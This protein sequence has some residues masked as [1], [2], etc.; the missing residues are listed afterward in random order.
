[1][2]QA[3]AAFKKFAPKKILV[4]GDVGLDVYTLGK[5]SRLSPEAPVNIQDAIRLANLAASIVVGKVGT[6]T[7]TPQDIIQLEL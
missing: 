1:M 7:V 2:D 5:A 3:I 6:A 4:V